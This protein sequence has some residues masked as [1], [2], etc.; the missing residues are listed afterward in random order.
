MT[1]PTIDL[2]ELL[3]KTEDADFLRQMVGFAAQRLMELA[4]EGLCGASPNW[5]QGAS[6]ATTGPTSATVTGT[7]VGRPEPARSI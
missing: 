7:G 6:V 1:Y 2:N 4:L 3:G 5:L